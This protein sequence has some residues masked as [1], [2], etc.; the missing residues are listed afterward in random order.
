M[1]GDIVMTYDYDPFGSCSAMLGDVGSINPLTFSSEVFDSRLG[2]TYYNYRHFSSLDGRW[3]GRDPAEEHAFP[4]G[5]L[6]EKSSD[7]YETRRSKSSGALY[8]FV[9]NATIRYTDSLGL[10]SAD[11]EKCLCCMIYGESRG[12]SPTCQEAIGW[13]IHNRAAKKRNE[14]YCSVVS[15]GF[16]AYNGDNY[17]D[18]IKGCIKEKDKAEHDNSMDNCANVLEK[19]E[20]GEDPTKGATVFVNHGLPIRP[21]NFPNPGKLKKVSVRGCSKFDFYIEK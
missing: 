19:Y 20:S 7:K 2:L 17:N 16:D 4:D 12:Q 15:S 9:Q 3:L 13:V 21:P 1:H 6:S 10:A 11:G 5:V 8:L 14:D 18:C